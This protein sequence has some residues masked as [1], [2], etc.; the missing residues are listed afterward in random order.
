MVA[1]WKD[2]SQNCPGEEALVSVIVNIGLDGPGSSTLTSLGIKISCTECGNAYNV[3][4]QE[5]EAGGL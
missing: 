4:N 1:F 2:L 3:N 5:S